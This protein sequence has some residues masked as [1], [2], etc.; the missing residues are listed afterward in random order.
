LYSIFDVSFFS[1][2]GA[3]EHELAPYQVSMMM[4]MWFEVWW[5]S[6]CYSKSM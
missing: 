4:M 1:V 5:H 6:W 3:S 2:V